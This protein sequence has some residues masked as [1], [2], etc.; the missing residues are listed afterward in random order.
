MNKCGLKK[1][2]HLKRK[3]SFSVFL[4]L[5]LSFF[6]LH[7]EA[8]SVVTASW[9]ADEHLL[10]ANQCVMDAEKSVNQRFRRNVWV[11]W[12]KSAVWRPLVVPCINYTGE[13]GKN[14]S[15]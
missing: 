11:G 10:E 12:T 9:N 4:L 8:S 13:F 1:K 2:P 3:I 6:F 5:M 15:I 14:R 7:S